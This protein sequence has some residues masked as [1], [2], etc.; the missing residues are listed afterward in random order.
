MIKQHIAIANGN[1]IIVKHPCIDGFRTLLSEDALSVTQAMQA[2]H[3]LTGLE[4]LACRELDRRRAGL[5]KGLLA[6]DEQFNAGRTVFGAKA[7][8]VGRALIAKTGDRG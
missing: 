8:V 3:G 7:R 2:R 1:D 4:R 5:V 6:I